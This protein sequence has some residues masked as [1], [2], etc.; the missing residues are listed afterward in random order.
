VYL[1]IKAVTK[2][3]DA[4]RVPHD[5]VWAG[6]QKWRMAVAEEC[7]APPSPLQRDV[8]RVLTAMNIEWQQRV[9]GKGMR[10]LRYTPRPG[11]T[12]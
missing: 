1:L 10:A 5:L 9:R 6:A 8:C 2:S 12:P 11:L 7:A 3:M 4:H